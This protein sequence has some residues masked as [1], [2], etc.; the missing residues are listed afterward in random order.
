MDPLLVRL[1]EARERHDRAAA[2]HPR[3]PRRGP[4]SLI[5]R[6]RSWR[7]E[8]GHDVVG[9]RLLDELRGDVSY[10]FRLL[11]RSPAFTLVALLSLGLGIGANTAIFTLI[12]TVL[13]KTLPVEDPQ[14]LVL[15][16]QLR[17]EV[18]RQ[19]R[20]SVPVLRAAPRSQPLPLGY[21]GVRRA[22]V[23]GVDR[24]RAGASARPVRL[25]LLLR[26]A[27]RP[28]DH[29]TNAHARG[30]FRPWPRRSTG[31]GRCD[32]RRLLGAPLRQGSGGARE[33]RPG[34]HEVGD[35]RRR[36]TT[37]ILRASGRR[38]ARHHASHDAR[39][40]GSAI[41]AELVAER[42]RAA[43]ARR[44]RRGGARGSRGAVGRL[45]DGS[46]DASRQARL[47]QRHRARPR[48]QG[49]ERAAPAPTPSH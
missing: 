37:G 2:G 16:R 30:R 46:R 14:R 4:M 18:G 24:R 29:R 47:L 27:R 32:Q 48:G 7:K 26:P 34:R 44:E 11:R 6:V 42:D 15:R 21:R 43:R 33:E 22:H 49:R 45:L 38:T 13:V 17:R 35:H 19:Q 9:L 8:Q 39:R 36:H 1:G 3:P 41:E 25:R 10:A 31:R 20:P 40:T 23:Q 12:D 5:A 28:R